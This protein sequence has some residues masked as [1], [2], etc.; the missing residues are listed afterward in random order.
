MRVIGQVGRTLTRTRTRTR[1]RT[2]TYVRVI[3]QVGQ[4]G[5]GPGSRP[6]PRGGRGVVPAATALQPP[7]GYQPYRPPLPSGPC[8][9]ARR[10]R[11]VAIR[12]ALRPLACL[13][14][15][16][17]LCNVTPASRLPATSLHPLQRH[18]GLSPAC[19][20]DARPLLQLE[21]IIPRALFRRL[22]LFAFGDA[23]AGIESRVVVGLFASNEQQA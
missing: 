5:G 18:S 4:R 22:R 3:G 17:I 15:H 14:R 23:F 11:F 8:A 19:N 12:R 1:T 2:L 21:L 20:D 13:Q 10:L 9:S 16:S 7:R 6:R